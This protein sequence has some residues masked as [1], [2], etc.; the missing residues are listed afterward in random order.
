MCYS[1]GINITSYFYSMPQ[2]I[3]N[4]LTNKHYTHIHTP[5]HTL[6]GM[7]YFVSIPQVSHVYIVFRMYLDINSKLWFHFLEYC[8]LCPST[9]VNI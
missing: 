3:D 1:R 4:C 8:T 6:T 7:L 2:F 5:T 9:F